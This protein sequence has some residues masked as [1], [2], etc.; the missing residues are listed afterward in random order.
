MKAEDEQIDSGP[1][2]ADQ[3]KGKRAT[4]STSKTKAAKGPEVG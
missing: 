1:G 2:A 3:G 4:G